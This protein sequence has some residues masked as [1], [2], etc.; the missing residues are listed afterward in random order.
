MEEKNNMDNSS[1]KVAIILIAI[2]V[3]LIIGV[4]VVLGGRKSDMQKAAENSAY[5][6]LKPEQND[7]TIEL[8]KDWEHE[9]FVPETDQGYSLVCTNSELESSILVIVTPKNN[10]LTVNDLVDAMEAIYEPFGVELIGR[11]D[12]TIND[13]DGI[14]YEIIVGDEN[15]GEF[16]QVGFVT[17]GDK[18]S[19][20][21]IIQS[22]VG[23]MDEMKPTFDYVINSFKL[24]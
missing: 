9:V 6:L 10:E 13:A 20:S 11:E 21:V 18:Y 16:Y 23:V 12:T 4:L 8:P 17:I 22:S 5:V 24:K 19:F 7:F 3:I 15:I 1:K 14:K 2:T